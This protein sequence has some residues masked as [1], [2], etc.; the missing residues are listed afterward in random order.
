MLSPDENKMQGNIDWLKTYNL[1]LEDVVS[2]D[3]LDCKKPATHYAQVRC[4]NAVI[5]GCKDCLHDA[6]KVVLWMVK[7]SKPIVC[8]GCKKSNRPEGWLSRPQ[9]LS[10]L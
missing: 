8:Q 5:I 7:Q 10:L 2:C 6:Y 1:D 4:C 3:T 9:K